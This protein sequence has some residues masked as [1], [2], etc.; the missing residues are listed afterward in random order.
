MTV[1]ALVSDAYGGRG[2][3][4]A[5][6][7]DLFAALA[8]DGTAVDVLSRA[9]LAEAAGAPPPGVRVDAA[10][11]GGARPF[12][13]AWAAAVRRGRYD[14]VFCGHA[15]LAPLAALAAARAG[16]PFVLLVHGIEAW[17]PPYWPATQGRVATA[18]TLAAARRASVV[19]AVSELT[20]GRFARRAGLPTER[21]TV[22]PNSVDLEAFTPGPRRADLAERYGLAG[23]DV[24][25]TLARL[26]PEERYKGV[27]EVLGAL[28]AVAARVPGVAYLIC[29]GGADRARLERRAAELGVA[30]RVV[31]AGYV[32]EDEK[33]D[34]YRLAD[35]FAMP[36][37]GEGFG[38]VYLEAL[39]CGVP[40][41]ASSADASRE[42]VRGGALGAVVDPTDQGALADA[43]CTA[44]EGP[45]GVP[46]G[47][48]HFSRARFA[49]RW[50]AVFAGLAR[51]ARRSPAV[52]AR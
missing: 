3:M 19:V 11:A 21:T 30:D 6:H 10:A 44:L 18:L 46:P 13:R 49:D 31:F 2:G 26:S 20:R 17:G 12:V 35:V 25:M 51:T 28:P 4:A 23:R 42:A 33:A 37:R 52:P 5:V 48:D 39:A 41:V 32:P 43:I 45:K 50:R 29:G 22:V 1:L 40:V 8:A 14:A 7:R 27:D 9:P 36:G 16:V 47:L 34:H 38:I 24:V 15:H